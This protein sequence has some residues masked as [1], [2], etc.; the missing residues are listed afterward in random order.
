MS[1]IGSSSR[2]VLRSLADPSFNI[3]NTYSLTENALDEEAGYHLRIWV[4]G[5]PNG[6]KDERDGSAPYLPNWQFRCVH[7]SDTII[8]HVSFPSFDHQ[9]LIPYGD[10]LCLLNTNPNSPVKPNGQEALNAN[11]NSGNRMHSGV[12]FPPRLIEKK[13]AVINHAIV[14]V[15]GGAG[16]KASFETSQYRHEDFE[17]CVCF[18]RLGFV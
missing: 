1:L 16:S 12:H 15:N 2:N 13:Q 6:G 9:F 7:V 14:G 4:A 3:S 8:C 18:A 5:G 10:S 17:E 11:S